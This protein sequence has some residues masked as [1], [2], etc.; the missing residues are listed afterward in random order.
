MT[1]NIVWMFLVGVMVWGTGMVFGQ[2][3]PNKPVRIFTAE[4]GGG[5]DFTARLISPVLTGS[6]GQ[7]VIVENRTS[8][9]SRE[10]AAKAPPDGYTLFLSGNVLWLTAFLQDNLPDPMRDFLPV[11]MVTSTPSILVV[12]PSLPVRSVQGLIALAKAKPGALNYASTA[13]GSPPSL[14]GELFKALAGINIAII[15][16]KGGGPAINALIGGQMQLMFSSAGPVAQQ[17]KSGRLRALAVTSAEPS[18]LVPGLPT[19]AAS[20]VPGYELAT[21]LGIFVPVKTSATI[22]RQ[23]NQE[24][25]RAL[26][27]ADVK[28]KLLNSGVEPIGNSPEQFVAIIKADAARMGKVIKDAGIR[29][30]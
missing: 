28:E 24:I 4:A 13:P 23:L 10:T 12:H 8:I 5:N 27:Q 29:I 3:Y 17:I 7:Q 18:A 14:G 9:I 30:E 21:I 19:M 15:P 26:N 16:Y 2:T 6:L 25:V 11:T 20:G 1:R 22:I